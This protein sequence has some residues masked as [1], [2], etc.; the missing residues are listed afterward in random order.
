MAREVG[1]STVVIDQALVDYAALVDAGLG[2]ADTSAL[3][4]RKQPAM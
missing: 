4:T 1:V 3:I 2:D